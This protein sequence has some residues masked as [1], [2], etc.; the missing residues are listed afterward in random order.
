MTAVRGTARSILDVLPEGHVG[1][2]ALVPLETADEDVRELAARGVR[3]ERSPWTLGEWTAADRE[4][5]S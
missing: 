3:A 4:G 5:E 1:G 2:Y